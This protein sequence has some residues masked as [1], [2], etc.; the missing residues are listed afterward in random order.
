MTRSRGMTHTPVEDG[1]FAAYSS[2]KPCGLASKLPS[3]PTAPFA[4]Q[5][6]Q[7]APRRTFGAACVLVTPAPVGRKKGTP[8]GVRGF[9]GEG[10]GKKDRTFFLEDGGFAAYSSAKGKPFALSCREAATCPTPHLRCCVRSRH[11]CPCGAQKRHAEW[12][13]LRLAGAGG[14]EPTTP[15]FGDWCSTD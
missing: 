7:L 8:N 9:R 6:G 13:A 11:S 5:I 3:S 14:L 15:S 4:L 1:G 10:K 12:R 2:R